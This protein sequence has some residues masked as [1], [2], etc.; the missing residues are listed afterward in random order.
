MKCI[1]T[2]RL[3]ACGWGHAKGWALRKC[4]KMTRLA[5]LRIGKTKKGVDK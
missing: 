3:A 1:M 2:F 5:A 4:V